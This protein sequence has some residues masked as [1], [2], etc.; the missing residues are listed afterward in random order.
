MNRN[1]RK[2]TIILFL[3]FM[4]ILVLAMRYCK[5]REI[6]AKEPTPKKPPITLTAEEIEKNKMFQVKKYQSTWEERALMRKKPAVDV[7][8]TWIASLVDGTKEKLVFQQ[9]GSEVTGV[10]TRETKGKKKIIELK[11]TGAISK[12]D[13]IGF[14]TNPAGGE[15]MKLIIEA[16]ENK[17]DGVSFRLESLDI[18]EWEAV[19]KK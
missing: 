17:M 7:S 2:S 3:A 10:F 16:K 19:R 6:Y 12:N 1:Y 18:V 13:L 15:A 4:A 8:G 11:F 5:S 14:T 9:K